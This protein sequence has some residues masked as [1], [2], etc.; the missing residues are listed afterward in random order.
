MF[1]MENRGYK[2]CGV[3]PLSFLLG[4]MEL[5]KAAL[6]FNHLANLISPAMQATGHTAAQGFIHTTAGK[7]AVGI[8]AAG[9]LGGGAFGVYNMMQPEPEKPQTQVQ[10]ET[11]MPEPV[12]K[13]SLSEAYIGILDSTDSAAEYALYDLDGD[14]VQELLISEETDG[15]TYA[16]VYTSEKGNAGYEAVQIE[17]GFYFPYFEVGSIAPRIAEDGQEPYLCYLESRA[18]DE[19]TVERITLN[20]NA[21]VTEDTGIV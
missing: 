17:K 3:V 11:Q 4:N 10:E 13:I 2:L 18:S 7:I 21:L 6:D 14:S 19:T 12:E 16:T 20:G 9:L 5:E 1:Y 8:V 15:K